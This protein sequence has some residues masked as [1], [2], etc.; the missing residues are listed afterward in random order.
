M[1]TLTLV[2]DKISRCAGRWPGV[3]STEGDVNLTSATAKSS[4]STEEG[5]IEPVERAADEGEGSRNGAVGR[6]SELDEVHSSVSAYGLVASN[7][8]SIDNLELLSLVTRGRVGRTGTTDEATV[9]SLSPAEPRRK[10]ALGRVAA[11]LSQRSRD[12]DNEVGSGHVRDRRER[13]GATGCR[14]NTA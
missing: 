11:W 12:A 1:S 4:L 2:Y 10:A 3:R 13:T 7:E 6:D 14:W 8:L 5:I 9:C